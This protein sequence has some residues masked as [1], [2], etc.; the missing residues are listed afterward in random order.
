[1]PD[2]VETRI[3][4]R[5][6]VR[7]WRF[8]STNRPSQSLH[9]FLKNIKARLLM[10]KREMRTFVR[11]YPWILDVAAMQGM[12][13]GRSENRGTKNAKLATRLGIYERSGRGRVIRAPDARPKRRQCALLIESAYLK[14]LRGIINHLSHVLCCHDTFGNCHCRFRRGD[15]VMSARRHS[16]LIFGG[17][18]C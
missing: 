10:R 7:W 13:P 11:T 14:C 2:R 9:F 3:L 16:L 1:M 12:C 15:V 8:S 17:G 4:F 5:C 18:Y 6:V